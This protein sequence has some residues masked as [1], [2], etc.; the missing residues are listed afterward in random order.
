[1]IDDTRKF[2]PEPD[3]V[4]GGSTEQMPA[5]QEQT[6]GSAEDVNPFAFVDDSPEE[7]EQEQVPVADDTD[8]LGEFDWSDL[9]YSDD[10]KKLLDKICSEVGVHKGKMSQVLK[11]VQEATI[12]DAKRVLQAEGDELKR[13]WGKNYDENLRKTGEFIKR[14]ARSAGWT[15]EQRN[16]YANPRGYALFYDVMRLTG[17][18][19]MAPA[20]SAPVAEQKPVTLESVRADIRETENRW[21]AAKKDN[22][23]TLMKEL[24]D[25]HVDL[26]TEQKRL[27]GTYQNK[28]APRILSF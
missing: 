2:A 21:F 13:W 23:H 8:D 18:R 16:A 11:R 10:D 17:E 27:M 3:A 19:R 24:S 5:Q 1:M 4:G 22:N 7:A 26:L 9:S 14:F 28:P 15:D 20:K 12:A 25:R 6:Q